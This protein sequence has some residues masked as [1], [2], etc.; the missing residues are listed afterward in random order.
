MPEDPKLYEFEEDKSLNLAVSDSPLIPG[1]VYNQYSFTSFTETKFK[2]DTPVA[3]QLKKMLKKM[4]YSRR[5]SAKN[6]YE[7]DSDKT[8]ASEYI[9]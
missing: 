4:L 2:D 1:Y 6:F 3:D 9:D 7:D 8:V 5:K